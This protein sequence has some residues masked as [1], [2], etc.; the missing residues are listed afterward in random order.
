LQQV[1][2]SNKTNC[3]KIE[4]TQQMKEDSD[5]VIAKIDGNESKQ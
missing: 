5:S 1:D 3:K 4:E 2:G